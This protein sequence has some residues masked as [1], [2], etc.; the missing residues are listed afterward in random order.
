[1]EPKITDKSLYRYKTATGQEVVYGD[2][3]LNKSA[4]AGATFISGPTDDPLKTP[5]TRYSDTQT[6]TGSSVEGGMY[7]SGGVKSVQTPYTASEEEKIREEERKKVQARIDAINQLAEAELAQARRVGEN[8]LGKGR[9]LA[10]ARGLLGS[11]IEE[12]E[13]TQIEKLNLEEQSAIR[14]KK[15]AEINSI[16]TGVENTAKE[17]IEARKTEAT[18]NAEDYT[19]Y[20]T[21][22]S[23]TAKDRMEKL[24]KAGVTLSADQ[25]MKLISQT[26]YDEKT[27]DDLY[28]SM[29]IVNSTEI[30]NKD[31][32]QII[33]NKAV[34]FKQTKDPVTGAIT[35]STEEL[36]LPE[37]A[38]KIKDTVARDDGIYVFYEDG[39]YKKVGQPSGT[40]SGSD[41]VQNQFSTAYKA[42]KN[43][44]NLK[45]SAGKTGSVFENIRRYWTGATP[46]TELISYANTIRTQALALGTNPDLKKFFGPQMSNADVQLLLSAGTSLD[47]EKQRPEAFQ[48]QLTEVK[49]LFDRLAKAKGISLG[50]VGG[51]EDPYKN[52]RTQLQAGEILVNRNGK[53]VAV[54]EKEILPTDK[55][56]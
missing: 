38:S 6:D 39:T 54:T 42:L 32:P 45:D 4:L 41:L 37:S 34:F 22:I 55:R 8:R 40:E 33:G 7:Q 44:E 14:A 48:K 47:P 15:E 17:L 12:T 29:K 21:G 13:A 51:E 3:L 25:R 26:G 18:R 1:M 35:F 11:P 19:K 43:A 46:N 31:K 5:V 16:L 36:D 27:F 28:K 9:A 52:F 50:E 30:I 53:A 56:L 23:T 10:S 20:L 49:E 2:P 24:A